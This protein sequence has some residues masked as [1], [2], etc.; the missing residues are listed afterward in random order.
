MTQ[1]VVEYA[2]RIQNES[3][4][5]WVFWVHAS[6]AGRFEE[7]YKSI[8]Q[9]L[10]LAGWQEPEADIL[11]IV[12]N[13]LSDENNGRW[14]MVVDNV[15]DGNVMF[16]PQ[17]GEIDPEAPAMAFTQR[18]LA[19]YLP[20]SRNGSIVITTRNREVA[21]RLIDYPEDILDLGPMEV[22]EAVVL[23]TKK[24]MKTEGDRLRDD[25]VDLARQLD[26]M[27]L[28]MSQA[29][30]YVNQRAPRMTLSRYLEVLRGS[31]DGRSQLLQTA[32]PDRRRD[33]QALNSIITTWYL[34][35]DHVRRT[36]ESA[37]R[38]LS[39]MCLFDRAGIPDDLLRGRYL[40]GSSDEPNVVPADQQSEVDFENDI[41]TLRAYSLIGVGTSDQL[42]EMHRLVQFTTKKWLEVRGE[43]EPWKKRYV[44]ILDQ[45]FPSV[46]MKPGLCARL[47][48]P[49]FKC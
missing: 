45:T 9:R 6:S 19:D 4:K 28:A 29:A 34:S 49:T 26:C 22:D 21:E 33:G 12:H 42:F 48:S 35:F 46:R 11:G 32:I 5:P 10:Q 41:T 24:L 47:F 27:P 17:S 25:L 2:Y 14:T 39:L 43:L 38:L 44:T 36:R 16:K 37:A 23:L 31:D 20:S 13:W 7:G 18:P 1:V 30:A 15:D 8:A 40:E 3:P